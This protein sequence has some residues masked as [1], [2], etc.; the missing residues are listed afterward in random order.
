MIDDAGGNFLH[1]KISHHISA[2][3]HCAFLFIESINDDLQTMFV[4]IYVIAIKLDGK[5]SA[6]FVMDTYI[7]TTTDAEVIPFGNDVNQTFVHT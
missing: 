1:I 4:F 6:F 2:D 7:P 3:Y 5:L